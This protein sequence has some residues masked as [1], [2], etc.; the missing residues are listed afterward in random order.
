MQDSRTLSR[1]KREE[2]A[3]TR[4]TIYSTNMADFY[5]WIWVITDQKK[6]KMGLW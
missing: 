6:A 3:T 5:L 4:E 1:V 2:R